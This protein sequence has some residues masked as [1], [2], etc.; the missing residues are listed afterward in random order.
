MKEL[1]V[2]IIGVGL[3][4]GD[5]QYT[6]GGATGFFGHLQSI[7]SI[8]D[9]G[10]F[11]DSFQIKFTAFGDTDPAVLARIGKLYPDAH[12]SETCFDILDE[13][14]VDV[15]WVATPTVFHKEYFLRAARQGIHIYVEKPVTFWPAEIDELIAA[16]DEH[17]IICQVGLSGRNLPLVPYLAALYQKRKKRWGQLM[18][19]VFRDEQEKPYLARPLHPSTWRKD[20]DLAHAGIL[21]EHSCHDLDALM[22]IFGDIAQVYGKVKY[23]AD[24]EDIEDSVA[25]VLELENGASISM[26][27]MW[28]NVEYD[29]RFI[30]VYCENAFIQLRYG[31]DGLE[32][33]L[34][35]KGKEKKPQQLDGLVVMADYLTQ[36]G[37]PAIQPLPMEPTRFGNI[38]FFKS[39]AESTPASPALEDARRVQEIIES[40]YQSSR[41]GRPISL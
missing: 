3:K 15:V 17:G 33:R 4:G 38:V 2:G 22:Y 34:V 5:P 25:A 20:K 26:S 27:S 12:L 30:E 35:E 39:L 28:T 6:E 9:E 32:Y 41:E 14:M 24:H 19:I 1:R 31:V 7:Q 40:I 36:I 10:I 37:M 21:F 13:K 18:N 16:R 8:I 23:F 11:D 29:E